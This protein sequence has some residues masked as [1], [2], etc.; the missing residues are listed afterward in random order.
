MKRVTRDA[1][2]WQDF[3]KSSPVFPIRHRLSKHQTTAGV[4]LRI[5]C[6]MVS[7]GTELPRLP[8]PTLLAASPS[9]ITRKVGLVEVGIKSLDKG[10]QCPNREVSTHNLHQKSTRL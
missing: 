2:D 8:G 10:G 4:L 5:E 3:K 6:R 7:W 9:P 1:L